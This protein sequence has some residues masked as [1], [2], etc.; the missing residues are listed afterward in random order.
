MMKKLFRLYRPGGMQVSGYKFGKLVERR[1]IELV[2]TETESPDQSVFL[3]LLSD[4]RDEVDS[5]TFA[6]CRVGH[7]D[8]NGVGRYYDALEFLQNKG[9]SRQLPLPEPVK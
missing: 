5:D 3:A 8:D 7:V 6:D 4:I 2:P 1:Y 9:L